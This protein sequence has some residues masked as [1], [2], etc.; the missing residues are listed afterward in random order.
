MAVLYEITYLPVG[1]VETL[2]RSAEYSYVLPDG[3]DVPV[4]TTPAWCHRCAARTD[5]EEL[6]SLGEIDATIRKYQR[7]KWEVHGDAD[8]PGDP[9]QVRVE[10]MMPRRRWRVARSSPPKFLRCGSTDI[11][12][13]PVHEPVPNPAGPGTIEL[14]VLGFSDIYL[15]RCYFTPEGDR[16]PRDAKPT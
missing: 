1:R 9:L 2:T 7:T 10:E 8:V 16:I 14:R 4:H 15:D 11:L 13:F 6:G 12:A 3:S 5:A